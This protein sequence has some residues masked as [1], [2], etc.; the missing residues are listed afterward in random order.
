MDSLFN[1]FPYLYFVALKL[2]FMWYLPPL[3]YG[4]LPY[5]PKY[6]SIISLVTFLLGPSYI[7]SLFFGTHEIQI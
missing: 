7:L 6:S 1:S 4:A 2:H 5:S 3:N